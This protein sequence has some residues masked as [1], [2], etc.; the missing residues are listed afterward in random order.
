MI[1]DCQSGHSSGDRAI[2]HCGIRRLPQCFKA[3]LLQSNAQA[4]S[5]LSLNEC[6]IGDWQSSMNAFT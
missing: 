4:T 2:G 3:A 5:R 6:P 1:D